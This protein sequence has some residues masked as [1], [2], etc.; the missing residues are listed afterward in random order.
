M[1]SPIEDRWRESLQP[2]DINHL[3]KTANEAVASEAAGGERILWSRVL[4]VSSGMSGRRERHVLPEHGS[5]AEAQEHTQAQASAGYSR[6]RLTIQQVSRDGS[7]T[8]DWLTEATTDGRVVIHVDVS[9]FQWWR[10]V[11]TVTE[12]PE[13][14]RGSSERAPPS[15]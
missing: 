13:A 11:I 10:A 4:T 5:N 8:G 1:L 14:R 2:V 7:H 3:E 15:A 9:A 12:M 6:G